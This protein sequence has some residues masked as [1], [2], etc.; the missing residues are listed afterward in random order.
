M[1]LPEREPIF[2]TGLFHFNDSTK[3]IFKG[4]S[5]VVVK[6]RLLAGAVEVLAL[7]IIDWLKIVIIN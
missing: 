3:V 2:V 5:A 4:K 1:H 7:Y 6:S